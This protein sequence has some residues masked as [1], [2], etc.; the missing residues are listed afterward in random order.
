MLLFLNQENSKFIFLF[1]FQANLKRHLENAN[2][3]DF[4]TSEEESSEEQ[5]PLEDSNEIIE[6]V[7]N[8]YNYKDQDSRTKEALLQ[9]ISPG[10]C[11]IC[12][13]DV[14]RKDAIWSCESCHCSFHM[15]CIQRWAQDSIYQVCI[16]LAQ[17]IQKKPSGNMLT[18][19]DILNLK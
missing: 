16:I 8:A 4:Q 15:N 14:K 17:Y 5:E 1:N 11:L 9:S 12:I 3:D 18:A 2:F 19:I 7:F 6:K 13:S 10:S